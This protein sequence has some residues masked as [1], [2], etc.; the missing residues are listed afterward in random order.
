MANVSFIEAQFP[1]FAYRSP[2]GDRHRA[3][4]VCDASEKQTFNKKLSAAAHDTD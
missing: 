4:A 3:K 2:M 1:S